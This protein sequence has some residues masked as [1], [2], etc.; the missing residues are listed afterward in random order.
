MSRFSRIVLVSLCV[1]GLALAAT[2]AFAQRATGD[3][4][5]LVTDPS[6]AV[7]P[8]ATVVVTNQGTNEART[9][10][11]DNTG[12][13]RVGLLQPGKYS[14]KTSAQGFK[15][16]EQREIEVTVGF[17]SRIDVK[18]EVGAVAET[19]TVEASA[20]LVNSES[21]RLS[22]LVG[23]TRIANMPLNGRNIYD[24]VRLAPG[25]VGV[26]G[27][28][29]EN[30]AQTSV[31][32]NRVNFNGFLMDG[33]ANKGLSGGFNAQPNPDMVQEFRVD[34]NNL[35]AEFGNSAGAITSLVTKQ[36]S[37][38]LH[39]SV[40]EYLRNDK[41]DAAE[42]FQH[43]KEGKPPFRF[44]QFGAAGG[45]PIKKDKT[46]FFAS[47]EGQRTRAG[48]TA[49]YTVDAPEWRN[50]VTTNF[51][52]S[53]AALLYKTFPFKGSIKPGST[54][55]R[56]GVIDNS[57]LSG[58][59]AD[60][61]DP[62]T[63]DPTRVA[64]F[65][66]LFSRLPANMPIEGAAS[67]TGSSHFKNPFAD[68]NQY[69]IRVDHNLTQNDRIFGRWFFANTN[70]PSAGDL[71]LNNRGFGSPY[72]T[73]SPNSMISWTHIFN[74][75]LINEFRAGYSR[76]VGLQQAAFP[77]VPSIGLDD[78]HLGFGAY[79]GYPQFFIENVF[80]YQDLVSV[81]KGRH[82]LKMGFEVKRNQENSEFNVGRPSYYFLDP[83]FFAIDAPYGMA[84]G[85]FPGKLTGVGPDPPA[86]SSNI[87]GW[88]NTE[89]G[90]FIQDDWKV[91][92]RLT[93]NLGLRY[94]LYQRHT[95]KYNLATQFVF[96][97]GNNISERLRNAGGPI[98]GV[99]GSVGGFAKAAVAGN[100]AGD[101]NNFGP[102]FGFAYDP[103][104]KGRTAIRGGFG[105]SYES[106]FYN[107]ISN[108]R[109]NP[110][111]YNFAGLF[112]D[113]GGGTDYILYGPPAGTTPSFTGPQGV[114][115]RVAPGN[116]MGYDPR[117]T[118]LLATLT[119]IPNPNMRDPYVYS[120]FLGIEQ[121]FAG[122]YALKVNYVGG[123]AHKL[124]RSDNM[125]RLD[126]GRLRRRL[127]DT[128]FGAIGQLNR[129]F[130]VLRIWQNNVNSNYNSLQV[131]LQKR[132]SR[133]LEF[134]TNYTWSHSI[135][136]GST[137]HSHAT[138]ANGRAGGDGFN[139]SAGNIRLDRGDSVFDVRHRFTASW[140][141]ELPFFRQ[142]QGV[143]GHILGGWQVN[144]LVSLQTGSPFSVFDRRQPSFN[145]ACTVG[146]PFASAASVCTNSGGDYNLDGERNDR[147]NAPAAS[148]PT[149]APNKQAAINGFLKRGDFGAPA[150]GTVG[151][152][153]RNTFRWPGFAQT[154]FSLFKNIKVREGMSVQFRTEM[155]NILNG[156]NFL[157]TAD[158]G[159][160]NNQL[161][162]PLLSK[163]VKTFPGRQIQFGLKFI[164]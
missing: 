100:T 118:Q 130:N 153:G 68:G 131:G 56:D 6:G 26:R 89:W 96:G 147:P 45:G 129:N 5:G 35:S 43:T 22:E 20:P 72:K 2:P 66:T 75:T 99:G 55:T 69:S 143:V 29:S 65:A 64:A 92:P 17:V 37:N 106:T 76:S 91:S 77:G 58:T 70:D 15:T 8:N 155:F 103:F 31:N 150:L 107:A 105:V 87:R 152:L 90:G 41:L 73:S 61:T 59:L 82:N 140:V 30:G 128:S 151:T 94:D 7:I 144:G 157:Q 162:S 104:G 149:S 79:N 86:L 84:G 160:T 138:T 40:W 132:M 54:I 52:N 154:D 139:T 63:V 158:S 14:V 10:Q 34:T 145:K 53:V 117:N 80:N 44:N 109:W 13:Y 156:T 98:A 133:G 148:V 1:L 49:V 135:D 119:G 16:S 159:H 146:V 113:L 62:D 50:F 164:F 108:S 38:S 57:G 67:L 48:Q 3:I 110:P 12:I 81:K 24:L 101:H 116:I 121:Q 111:F 27:V 142:Q 161:A 46:F 78:G 11:T 32:G 25:A 122:S 71:G 28:V 39:G 125:N 60:Y 42:F 123:A 112:N 93:L 18:M 88:R 83:F 51:P 124:F 85:T 47:F 127:G 163:S 114:G 134:T 21:G 33:V 126:D 137:W 23:G 102:R 9:T 141:Y 74:P 95:E 36:G 115:N 136:E 97:P 19:V 4:T 120:F